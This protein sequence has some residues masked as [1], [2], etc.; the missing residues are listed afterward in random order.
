MDTMDTEQETALREQVC[1]ALHNVYDPELGVNVVDLGLIYG[2][3]FQEGRHVLITMTL[4]TPGCPM[5]ETIGE[6]E[7]EQRGGGFHNAHKRLAALL[8]LRAGIQDGHGGFAPRGGGWCHVLLLL[9]C[10]GEMKHLV[11]AL[12]AE[13]REGDSDFGRIPSAHLKEQ[14][15]PVEREILRRVPLF[16][17]LDDDDLATTW[18]ALPPLPSSGA[19]SGATSSCWKA[20]GWSGWR[21]HGRPHSRPSRADARDRG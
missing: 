3:E 5:H 17:Q 8:Q 15:M 21:R 20:S 16:A 4:T 9:F 18:C 11:E 14:R 6:A 19:M 12:Y 10:C 13:E 2:V 1:E 7:V